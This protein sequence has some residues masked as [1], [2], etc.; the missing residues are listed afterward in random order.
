M[1]GNYIEGTDRYYER[2]EI[3]PGV[4]RMIVWE[5]ENMIVDLVISDDDEV[6]R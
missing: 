4:Y 1:M 3:G 2:R 5:G 6:I